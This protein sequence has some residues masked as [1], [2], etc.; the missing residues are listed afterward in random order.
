MSKFS[1]DLAI[2]YRVYPKMSKNPPPIFPDNKFKL[3]E[4]CLISLKRSVTGMRVKLWAIL[5]G[6]PPEYEELFERVWGKED[7]VIVRFP[8][9]PSAKTLYEASRILVEQ[10]DSEMVYFG[11][12]DYFYLPGQFHL[13]VDFLKQNADADFATLF[14]APDVYNTELHQLSQQKRM[15]EGKVWST[16]MSTTHTFLAKRDSLIELNRVYL[17]IYNGFKNSITPD[18][19]MWLALTKRR[20]FNPFKFTKWCFTKRYWAASMAIAWFYCWRQILFGR[21]YTLW[22]PRP[23]IANHMDAKLPAPGVDWQ[24]EFQKQIASVQSESVKTG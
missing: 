11:D 8:N 16:C 14:D 17:N 10:T 4:L 12:D 21:R 7:L 22:T 5:N 20:I 13:A 15:S 6:C 19:A 2:T 9:I 23:S 24:Q 3:V 1:Y 18:L